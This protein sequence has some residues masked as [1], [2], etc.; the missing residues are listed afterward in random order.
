M[1]VAQSK[2]ADVF[3][4]VND[5]T[6]EV[7]DSE[8]S[9]TDLSNDENLGNNSNNNQKVFRLGPSY[10]STMGGDLIDNSSIVAKID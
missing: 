1:E 7:K 4:N 5:T 10:C 2:K 9:L 3:T 8:T 6:I